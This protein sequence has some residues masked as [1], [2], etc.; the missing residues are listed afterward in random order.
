MKSNICYIDKKT[1]LMWVYNVHAKKHLSVLKRN[2]GQLMFV[3]WARLGQ[4]NLLMASNFIAY[5]LYVHTITKDII[6]NTIINFF[7]LRDAQSS[8]IRKQLQKLYWGYKWT[9]LR[10]DYSNLIFHLHQNKNWIAFNKHVWEFIW[11]KCNVAE[12]N[13]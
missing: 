6:R 10:N 8:A 13:N 9:N 11:N 1:I 7:I 12:I 2:F 3:R 4:T 5:L